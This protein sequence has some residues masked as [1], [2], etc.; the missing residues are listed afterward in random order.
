MIHRFFCFIAI[1]V[2]ASQTFAAK[3]LGDA[4]AEKAKE[5]ILIDY[6]TGAVLYEKNADTL[7]NPSSMTKVITVLL[8]FQRLKDGRLS[9]QDK[10][11]ISPKAWK[12]G[13]SRMF[14]NPNTFVT[15]EELLH[16]IITVSGNDASVALA[17]GMSGTEENAADE[18]TAIAREYGA[19]NTTLKN[20]HG[21]AAPGHLSTARDLA[22]ISRN[23][24]K[25]FPEYY[26]L[27]KEKSYT[28]NKISQPNRNPLLGVTH[29]N[30]DGLKT[31]MTDEGGYG[32]I[33]SAEKDGRRLILV[34]NGLSSEKERATVSEQLLSWGFREFETVTL[35]KAYTPILQAPTWLGTEPTVDL[36]VGKD[37]SLTLSKDK[38]KE[39]TLEAVYT[40]PIPA[41]L[42][43]EQPVG[44]LIIHIPGQEDQQVPLLAAKAVDSVGPFQR[45]FAALKHIIWGHG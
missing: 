19:T 1:L 14:L 2:L 41:P 30:A 27:F 29:L 7:T 25:N 18:M 24:I 6:E 32:L 9:M 4:Y 31:G 8:A 28:Y 34:I 13:G 44:N 17:E 10:L 39:I 11:M 42:T 26:P 36:I 21:L 3:S 12:T 20:A 15:V 16:G 38:K 33:G 37:V 5:V 22:L 23:L 45:V 40:S 43:Q 35:A